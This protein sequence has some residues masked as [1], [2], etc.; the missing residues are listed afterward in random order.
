MVA[1]D[2]GAALAAAS[3]TLGVQPAAAT[4]ISGNIERRGMFMSCSCVEFRRDLIAGPRSSFAECDAAFPVR[5]GFRQQADGTTPQLACV[6]PVGN[7]HSQ[8][9]AAGL[10]PQAHVDSRNTSEP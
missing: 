5:G 6:G 10:S 3:S 7:R 4:S 1:S 9:E 8:L 2:C